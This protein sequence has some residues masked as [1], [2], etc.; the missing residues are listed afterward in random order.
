MVIT[1]QNG[2]AAQATLRFVPSSR[3]GAIELRLFGGLLEVTDGTNGEGVGTH[4]GVAVWEPPTD[5][6]QLF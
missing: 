5:L 6:F 3:M 1:S 4:Y 2:P